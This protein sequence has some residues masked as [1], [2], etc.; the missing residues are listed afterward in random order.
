MDYT[1]EERRRILGLK[2]I[3][4]SLFQVTSD[5]WRKNLLPDDFQPFDESIFRAMSQNHAVEPFK[6]HACIECGIKIFGPKKLLLEHHKTHVRKPKF[7][8]ENEVATGR[9]LEYF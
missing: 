7:D 1:R 5:M 4:P 2:P 6:E 3:N 8:K 9:Y